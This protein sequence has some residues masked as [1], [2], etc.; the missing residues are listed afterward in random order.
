M[1][2]YTV[3]VD[4]VSAA[5]DRGAV[6]VREGFCLPAALFTVF[7]T[8]YHRLWGWAAILLAIGAGLGA[9]AAWSGL[10]PAVQVTLEAGTL[11]LVGFSANDWRRRGLA[12]RG[13]VL[14][15]VVA[16]SDLAAAEQRFFDRHAGWVQ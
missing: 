2:I 7:W 15:G 3:H 13:Y 4:P 5:Y 1:R 6:L 14:G 11:A 12:R 9:A 10:H 16:A 8:L